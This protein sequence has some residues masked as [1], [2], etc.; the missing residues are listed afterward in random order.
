MASGEGRVGHGRVP[1]VN[2]QSRDMTPGDAVRR[3]GDK[4]VIGNA[5]QPHAWR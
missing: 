3:R 5:A 4:E 2:G 1:V